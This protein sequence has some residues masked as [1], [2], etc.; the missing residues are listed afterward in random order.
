MNIIMVC[1]Q[2]ALA[3]KLAALH[4]PDINYIYHTIITVQNKK[5][6]IPIFQVL[7]TNVWYTSINC[8]YCNL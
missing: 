8:C 2:A 3:A 6:T 4:R 7:P 5:N 1:N